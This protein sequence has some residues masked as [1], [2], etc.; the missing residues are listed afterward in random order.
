MCQALEAGG[1]R[2]HKHAG[3]STRLHR[4]DTDAGYRVQPG[5]VYE[6]SLKERRHPRFPMHLSVDVVKLVSPWIGDLCVGVYHAIVMGR[7]WEE[8]RQSN[9]GAFGERYSLDDI[10]TVWQESVDRLR[11][12]QDVVLVQHVAYACLVQRPHEILRDVRA[13]C[14]VAFD[15]EAAASVI[16]PALYRFRRGVIPEGVSFAG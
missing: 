8:I 3:R 15:V 16:N 14:Q 2:V 4:A 10:R 13:A 7:S 12:R 1:L 11:V 9:E 5:D 6:P